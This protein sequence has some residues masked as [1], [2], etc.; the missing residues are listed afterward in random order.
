MKNI[1]AA[2]RKRDADAA[3]T[4]MHKNLEAARHFLISAIEQIDQE[5]QSEQSTAIG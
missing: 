4:A 3:A 5:K 2:F 1:H